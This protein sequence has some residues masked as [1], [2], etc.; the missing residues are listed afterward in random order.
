MIEC[1]LICHHI[2]ANQGTSTTVGTNSMY[3]CQLIITT[4]L[5][6]RECGE[7]SGMLVFCSL[8]LVC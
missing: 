3:E 7:V 5:E 1:E 2:H 6:C 4:Y 8:L